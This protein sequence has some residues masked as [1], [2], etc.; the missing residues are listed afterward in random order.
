[1][2]HSYDETEKEKKKIRV[3]REYG[4]QKFYRSADDPRKA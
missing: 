3:T 1:M 2:Y 4:E